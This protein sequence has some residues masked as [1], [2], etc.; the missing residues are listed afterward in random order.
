MIRLQDLITEATT[1]WFDQNTIPLA[2]PTTVG[3]PI[4][5]LM[6]GNFWNANYD[7][8]DKV[9]ARVR[10]KIKN[11]TGLDVTR[12]DF[13]ETGTPTIELTL[14]STGKGENIFSETWPDDELNSTLK[15]NYDK[16]SHKRFTSPFPPHGLDDVIAPIKWNLRINGKTAT[17]AHAVIVYKNEDGNPARGRYEMSVMDYDK[18]YIYEKRADAYGVVNYYALSSRTIK[19]KPG[20]KAYNA[21]KTRVFG[22]K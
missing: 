5:T 1:K 4:I 6:Y 13:Y 15:K 16:E 17:G 12:V 11:L 10:S 20:T 14:S 18:T 22:D 19:L 21:V 8:P 9:K 7:G 3:L 2:D